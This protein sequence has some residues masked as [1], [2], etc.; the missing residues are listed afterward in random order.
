MFYR[1]FE[2]RIFPTKEQENLISARFKAADFLYNT[3][4]DFAIACRDCGLE[5]PERIQ[6]VEEFNVDDRFDVD[7]ITAKFII[8]DIVKS[9]KSE[10]KFG[11][12]YLYKRGQWRTLKSYVLTYSLIDEENIQ[13]EGIGDVEINLHRPIPTD[14]KIVKVTLCH[15]KILKQY[16]ISVL[17]CF[18]NDPPKKT[19]NTKTAIGLDYKQDGLYVD[20]N[21]MSG[22]CPHF[23]AAERERL[24][25]LYEL[26][27]HKKKG[28]RR[29]NETFR[30]IDK[31]EQH[32]KNQRKDW[33]FKEARRLAETHDVICTETL[34]FHKMQE[35]NPSLSAKMRDN[36]PVSFEKKIINAQKDTG[37]I[38][39]KCSQ[40]FPSTKRCSAC[41]NILPTFSLSQRVYFCPNCGFECDRDQNAAQNILC[42]GLQHIDNH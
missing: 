26:L 21:G 28:S 30:K 5:F 8:K 19:I 1:N 41:G 12:H 7:E 9:I 13:L 16:Y 29:W 40:Y 25:A 6:W 38:L 15:R 42:E 24:N 18:D 35:T 32:I 17:V 3:I 20:S 36:A 2:Y 33:Q 23:R 27:S 31:L 11:K 22:D 4:I 39:V 34:N 37:G 14:G 10:E